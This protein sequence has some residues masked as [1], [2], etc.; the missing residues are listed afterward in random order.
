MQG[1]SVHQLEQEGPQPATTVLALLSEAGGLRAPTILL[2]PKK[3]HSKF[4]GRPRRQEFHS[5][6]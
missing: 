6:P 4:K 2:Q 3:V 5:D 1:R